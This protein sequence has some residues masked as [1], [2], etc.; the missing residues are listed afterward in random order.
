MQNTIMGRK[1]M[2]IVLFFVSIVQIRSEIC[3][4]ETCEYHFVVRRSRTM[5]HTKRYASGW[6]DS[7]LVELKGRHLYMKPSQFHRDTNRNTSV[8]PDDI[9]TA[10]GLS[11]NIIVV[12]DQ[13][14]GPP[15]EVTEGAQVVVHVENQ[16]IAQGTSIH[17]HGMHQ[18]RTSYMDGV[19]FITQCPIQPKQTFTYRFKADPVG[20]HWYHSH[21]TNQRADG[22]FG[23]LIVHD[24]KKLKRVQQAAETVIRFPFI[25]NDWQH[26]DASTLDLMSPWR[27]ERRGAGELVNPPSHRGYSHDGIKTSSLQYISGMINGKG[28]WNGNLAPLTEFNVTSNARVVFNLVNAGLEYAFKVS[29]DQ[30]MLTVTQS[31]G[32]DI[33]PFVCQSLIVYP[34]ESYDLE[35]TANQTIDKYWVRAVTLRAGTGWDPIPDNITWDALAILSYEGAT[36]KID[37]ESSPITC[38][39]DANCV[40]LNCPFA[41][42]PESENIRCHSIAETRRLGDDHDHDVIAGRANDSYVEHILNFG[43][44]IGSSINAHK[45]KNPNAPLHEPNNGAVPCPAN[46]ECATS[47]KGCLCTNTIA[48]KHNQL[49]R[50][51]F[52]NYGSY[53]TARLA[54]HFIHLHGHSFEILKMGYPEYNITTGRKTE[55]NTDIVCENQHCSLHHWAEGHPKDLNFDHPPLKDTVVVPSAGYVV[56]QF[57]ADNPGF[58]F[59]HCHAILH[60]M[61]G[62]ELAFNEAEELHLPPPKG[63]PTCAPFTWTAEEYNRTI[64]G[65]AET[66]TTIATT[67]DRLDVT[68]KPLDQQGQYNSTVFWAVVG[69]MIA[70]IVLLV[71]ALCCVVKRSRHE[72]FIQEHKH[73]INPTDSSVY[74]EGK[75]TSLNGSKPYEK[76]VDNSGYRS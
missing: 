34:G 36:G 40:V 25:L 45:F 17:W 67:T 69:P 42:Y 50:L 29:I 48:L 37:P 62:M 1:I 68:V 74:Y 52:T 61:E 75:L 20:T 27:Q 55:N 70:V 3:M 46:N 47:G 60:V 54:H 33:V 13:F 9:I 51:T 56:V 39:V 12:N 32:H 41:G 35:I 65:E 10:D 64:R 49:I 24:K 73:Q 2:R 66:T 76:G 22:L 63:F 16:F 44:P 8:N 30:H 5:M 57:R 14:P 19:S 31:D 72:K 43:F 4:N 28:R 15:I 23:M 6:E 53:P 7:N 38:L 71:I 26:T 21:I 18:R 58:W 59:M 11:R